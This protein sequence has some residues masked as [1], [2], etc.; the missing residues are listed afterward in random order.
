MFVFFVLFR[1]I[2]FL[3]R[4]SRP[5]AKRG[6]GGKFPLPCG[7]RRDAG[8]RGAPLNSPMMDH[9]GLG[10]DLINRISLLKWRGVGRGERETD[11]ERESGAMFLTRSPRPLII[12][13]H[14]ATG[15][16]AQ[17]ADQVFISDVTFQEP[18]SPRHATP[19]CA[20][21]DPGCAVSVLARP[22]ARARLARARTRIDPLEGSK[23]GPLISPLWLRSVAQCP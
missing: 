20:S 22:R 21:T 18:A 12:P 8:R 15:Q 10:L 11:C 7:A 3:L 1:I 2:I 17:H 14:T 5:M 9:A 23:I 16:H 4:F 13:K 19:R 6:G